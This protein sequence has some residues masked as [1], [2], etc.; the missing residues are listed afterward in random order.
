[1][2][3]N[4]FFFKINDIATVNYMYLKKACGLNIT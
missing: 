1:M 3:L 2:S 4:V